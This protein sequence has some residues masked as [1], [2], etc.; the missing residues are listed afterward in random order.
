MRRASAILGMLLALLMG[1]P[2]GV[3]A[4]EILTGPDGQPS[5]QTLSL[6]YAF[7]NDSFGTAAGYV[8]GVVGR[9]QQQ[10]S[11]LTTVMAGTKGSAMGFLIGRD[12]RLPWSERLFVD[13]VASIGYF[14]ENDLY[15]DGNPEYEDSRAGDNDSDRDDFVTG[16]GWDNYFRLKFKYLLPIG[17]GRETI[18]DVCPIDRGLPMHAGPPS[19]SLNPLTSGKTYLEVRPFYRS[20]SV[21]GDNLDEEIRTNGIN[22]GVYW[23]NRDFGP[24]PS[25][26]F[27]VRSKVSR[28]FG[29]L[30]SSG[31]WTNVDG[32]LDAYI[33]LGDSNHFRQQVI[34]FN[35][36]TAYSPSWDVQSD[37][38]IENRPPAYTGATLGG[39]WKL[40]GYPSQRFSDKAAVYYGLEWRLIPQWNPF[41]R[42]EWLQ[43]YLG[44]QWIQV[45]P[46]LELGRV[47]SSWN[48]EE[49][50]RDMKWSL[51]LGIRAWAKGIVARIDAASSEEGF[52][53][54]MMVG[55]P[56]QF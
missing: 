52:K 2:S 24:N 18:I 23:D 50:H 15:I 13:P 31:S 10:S 1:W 38:R 29:G 22:A 47:A 20:Q 37:G 8:Y 28:D 51:G 9:P 39:M 7:Y 32:E 19:F 42:S 34:G 43:R 36:W 54:Q 33:P 16:D 44:I 41:S 40:R 26:G 53:V 12:L 27:S 21:E 4:L 55:H 25:R 49:L 5:K 56:F 6:P 17:R 45:V 35:F 48:L 46:F 14:K 3:I 11:L 30:D